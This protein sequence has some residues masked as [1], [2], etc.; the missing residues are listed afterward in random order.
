MKPHAE[1]FRQV[2]EVFRKEG[3]AV[4]VFNDKHLSWNWDWAK[5]MVETSRKLNFA[6]MAGSSLPV[7]WRMPALDLPYGAEVEEILCV[8]IGQ[9]E[10]REERKGN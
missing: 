5:E 9:V 1:F 6:F 4:P 8:A 2:V 3:R 10:G 7:T